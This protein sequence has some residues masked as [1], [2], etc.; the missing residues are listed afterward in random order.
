MMEHRAEEHLGTA[1]S[2]K[3]GAPWSTQPTPVVPG[4][5]WDP[6]AT[7]TCALEQVELP[8]LG[9]RPAVAAPRI[10]SGRGSGGA[11]G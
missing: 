7:A 2:T 4:G 10:G 9:P 3:L 11:G 1:W 5:P 6:G 8:H